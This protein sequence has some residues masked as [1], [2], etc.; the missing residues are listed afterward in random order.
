VL[1]IHEVTAPDGELAG[2]YLRLAGAPGAGLEIVEPSGALAV[3]EGALEIVMARYGAPFDE[4]ARVTAVA[5]LELGPGHKLRHVRHLA[6][7]DVVQRDY[8]VLER[9]GAEALC[10]PGTTVAGA[11]QHLARAAARSG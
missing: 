6:G 3:P 5:E 11:L 8:L 10:A 4:Q 1:K 7:Y 9:P 2:I